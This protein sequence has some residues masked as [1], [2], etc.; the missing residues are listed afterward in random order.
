MLDIAEVDCEIPPFKYGRLR[1]EIDQIKYPNGT[2][3]M[4][5]T[6]WQT[7]SNE[8]SSDGGPCFDFYANQI[9]DAI[10]VLLDM[11]TSLENGKNIKII[12]IPESEIKRQEDL[13][14][15]EKTFWYKFKWWIQ[16]WG[17]Q[18]MPFSWRLNLRKD[19]EWYEM[20]HS[21]LAIG[22][23]RFTKGNWNG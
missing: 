21:F 1:G 2:E 8:S 14:K 11:K 9:D 4:L 12:D 6:I 20:K 19:D 18:F 13:K 3:K 5:C 16:D 23:F 7:K 17:I 22:P 15:E 10:N